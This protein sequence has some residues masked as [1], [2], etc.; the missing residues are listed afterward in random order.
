MEAVCMAGAVREQQEQ[1]RKG[2]GFCETWGRR[3]QG[4]KCSEPS[5]VPLPA[6]QL[7]EANI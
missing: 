4:A 5:P 6:F 2:G 7:G 1:M 3:L